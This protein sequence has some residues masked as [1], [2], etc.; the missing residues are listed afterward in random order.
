MQTGGKSMSEE[1]PTFGFAAVEGRQVEAS[2]DGGKMTTDAGVLLLRQAEAKINLF[3]RAAACFADGRLQVAVEHQIKNIVAQ[4]VLGLAA[5]YEDL[6]D[7]DTLRHDLALQ[8]AVGKTTSRREDC[9]PLA[10][11]STLNR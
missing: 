2:F 6:N 11:K 1:E 10:G 7:H 5:G 9:A 3:G 8:V 4:R